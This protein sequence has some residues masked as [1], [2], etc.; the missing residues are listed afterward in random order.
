MKIMFGLLTALTN[1]FRCKQDTEPDEPIPKG[2]WVID[3]PEI[4]NVQ[5]GPFRSQDEALE[6]RRE[7]IIRKIRDKSEVYELPVLTS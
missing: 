1:V 6:Y 3:L 5:L 7:Y 4:G 2:R